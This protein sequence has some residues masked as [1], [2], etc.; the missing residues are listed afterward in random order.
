[1]TV[2]DRGHLGRSADSVKPAWAKFDG[3]TRS[4]TAARPIRPAAPRS[5]RRASGS[6]SP[7]RPAGPR[8]GRRPPGCARRRRS[9]PARRATRPP[10]RAGPPGRRRAAAPPRCCVTTSRVLGAGQRDKVL[11]GGPEAAAA[12][13]RHLVELEVAVRAGSGRRGGDGGLGPRRAA[14]VRV[15]DDT[16]RVDDPRRNRPIRSG[17]VRE[18]D[19]AGDDP[20]GEPVHR[21][22]DRAGPEPSPLGRERLPD[23]RRQRRRIRPGERDPDE[24][25]DALDARRSGGA[26]GGCWRHAADHRRRGGGRR[27]GDR[28]GALRRG[29]L[30]QDEQ[31]PTEGRAMTT[32]EPPTDHLGP[33]PMPTQN[34]SPG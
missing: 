18:R 24:R 20:G 5:R 14:E 1:M 19:G 7:P 4:T 32:I 6:S 2:G 8:P 26:G 11:L 25:Q 31:P 3:W 22:R 21:G 34:R 27:D 30:V 15:E 16:G 33:A 12:A 17:R 29:S 23:Q 10:T 28:C 13:A 9:R